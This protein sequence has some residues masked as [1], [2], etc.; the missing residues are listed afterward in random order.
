MEKPTT[1]EAKCVQDA[2][3]LDAIGAMGIGRAFA[4]GGNHNRKMYDPD[5]KPNLNI[6]K[7]EYRNSKSTTIN[8][9]Y[10]K[11][12]LLKELMNTET[13]KK[14]AIERDE[15]MRKFVDEFMREWNAEI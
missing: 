1:I 13:G 6:T 11:L 3:R 14:I 12:F 5:I 8:H 9:F 15:F 4:F 2:D 10:E 7:E